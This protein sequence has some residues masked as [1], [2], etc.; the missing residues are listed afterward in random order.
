MAKITLK[1]T[2][3]L[4]LPNGQTLRPGA[5]TAVERW[6][7]LKNHN[8]VSAWIDAGLFLVDGKEAGNSS[9]AATGAGGE[10]LSPA[11]KAAKVAEEERL[12]KEQE[13]RDAAKAEADRLAALQQGGNGSGSGEGGDGEEAELTDEEKAEAKELGIKVVWNSKPSTI[14]AKVAEEK[15]KKNA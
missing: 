4:T 3:P 14:R 12:K 8:V 13:E 1:H 9:P 7:V 10:K 2:G 15:A 11:A 5:E 6:D